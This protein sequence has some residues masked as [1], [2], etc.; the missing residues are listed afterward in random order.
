ME[1]RERLTVDVDS[2]S[3]LRARQ[4][5]DDAIAVAVSGVSGSDQRVAV[6]SGV[7]LS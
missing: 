5:V 6:K 1:L 7:R 4:I 3:P 2:L